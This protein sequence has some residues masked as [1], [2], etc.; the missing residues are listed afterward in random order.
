MTELW[1]RRT[2]SDSPPSSQ[3][4]LQA[5]PNCR[6]CAS[7][8][9][10]CFC[11]TKLQQYFPEEMATVEESEDPS[12]GLSFLLCEMQR[13]VLAQ[14]R[15]HLPA[16]AG[17]SSECFLHG[18]EERQLPCRSAGPKA[19]ASWASRRHQTPPFPQPHSTGEEP[20][21]ARGG[22][23]LSLLMLR[24]LRKGRALL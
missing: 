20:E 23:H 10:S 4:R 2:N 19:Q 11:P 16:E 22:G 18:A 14:P 3:V 13:V 21:A 24:G 15:G 5:G 8:K 1:P 6:P 7:L 12:P 9:L 17:A